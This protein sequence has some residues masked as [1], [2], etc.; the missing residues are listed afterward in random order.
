MNG[1]V[2]HSGLLGGV[3]ARATG[4]GVFRRVSIEGGSRLECEAKGAAAPASYRVEVD[5]DVVSVSLVMADRWLSHSI[6][7][8]LLNTGDKLSELL[9]DELA[10]FGVRIGGRDASGLAVEHY[11]SED[12][13]FT[14]RT[15]LPGRASERTADEVSGVLLAYEACFRNLGDMEAD[16]DE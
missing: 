7:A 2:S 4:A 12:K 5:G 15:R 3:L 13:L 1:A 6:E 9:D 11:R 8:D 14:F 16:G 10:D